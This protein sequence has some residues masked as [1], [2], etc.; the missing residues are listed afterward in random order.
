MTRI[1]AIIL[2]I[3]FIPGCGFQSGKVSSEPLPFHSVYIQS[4]L[5]YSPLAKRL[6][7]VLRKEGINVPETSKDA[8]YTIAIVRDHVQSHMTSTN[9]T[10]TINTY[11]V[12][13]E[14]EYQIKDKNGK[15]VVASRTLNDYRTYRADANQ[16]YSSKAAYRIVQNEMQHRLVFKLI[17]QLH[18][19]HVVEALKV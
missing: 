9:S 13:Y 17:Q 16:V 18:S 7:Y 14:V 1:I 19:K 12:T 11:L 3:C 5:A 2:M 10:Q 6:H 4:K 8:P 15:V